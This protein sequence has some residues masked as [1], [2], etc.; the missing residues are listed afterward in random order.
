KLCEGA[1]RDAEDAFRTHR[2]IGGRVT[3]RRAE[4]GNRSW[5]IV[6][7]DGIERQYPDN[8]SQRQ[9]AST[10]STLQYQEP[11]CKGEV[12]GQ[13]RRCHLPAAQGDVERVGEEISA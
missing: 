13:L 6:G 12:D 9:S 8:D 7:V 4:A 1:K 3:R 2:V 5:Q 10:P 11:Q